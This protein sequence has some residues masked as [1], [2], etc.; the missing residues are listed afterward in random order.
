MQMREKSPF[1]LSLFSPLS[2][3]TM[4]KT[5]CT[6]HV[7]SGICKSREYDDRPSIS[8]QTHRTAIGSNRSRNQTNSTANLKTLAH[9][10]L[11]PT[12]PRRSF[13]IIINNKWISN[14]LQTTLKEIYPTTTYPRRWELL[15]SCIPLFHV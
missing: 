13:A 3:P 9:R 5:V 7:K 10:S 4:H 2:K 8:I 6:C 12:I 11:D 14:L 1:S 15:L